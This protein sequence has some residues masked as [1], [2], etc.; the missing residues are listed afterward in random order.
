MHRRSRIPLTFGHIPAQVTKAV[1]GVIGEW[2]S[3]DGLSG[4]LDSLGHARDEVNHVR[5]GEC[6]GGD[7]VGESVPVKQFGL[8]DLVKTV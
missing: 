2:C 3:Q 4:D 6:L 8:S 1:P 5:R 7:Q